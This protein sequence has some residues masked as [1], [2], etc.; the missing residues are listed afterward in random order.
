MLCSGPV[1][2]PQPAVTSTAASAVAAS[3]SRRRAVVSFMAQQ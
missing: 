2:G 1:A 3:A